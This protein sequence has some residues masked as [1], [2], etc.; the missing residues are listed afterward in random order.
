MKI[1]ANAVGNYS[2]A[3]FKTVAANRTENT[4]TTQATISTEEKKFF[5]GLYPAQKDEVMEYK[6][7]NS[8]GKVSGVHVGS[9]F[10]RRG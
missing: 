9:L 8:K 6:L 3:Y 1:T 10:D 2:P 7:Y 5:A 4:Q